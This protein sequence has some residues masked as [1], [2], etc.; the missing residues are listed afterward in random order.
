MT[1]MCRWKSR[2]RS[3]VERLRSNGRYSSRGVVL[4]ESA[5]GVEEAH[6]RLGV[7]HDDY[8]SPAFRALGQRVDDN[9]RG[10]L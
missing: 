2:S 7:R 3:S 10:R 1:T 5:L 9:L 8:P 4:D 6:R